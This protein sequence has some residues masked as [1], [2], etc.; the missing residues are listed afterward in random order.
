MDAAP[1]SPR[2]ILRAA[3]LRPLSEAEVLALE[4]RLTP[5]E[6]GKRPAV[7]RTKKPRRKRDTKGGGEGD[8]LQ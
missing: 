7:G 6:P 1:D 4:L 2:T 8:V 3:L 5:T